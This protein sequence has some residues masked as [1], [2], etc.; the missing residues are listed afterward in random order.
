MHQFNPAIS[1]V[2]VFSMLLIIATHYLTWKNINSYQ[3]ATIGVSCFLFISGYLYGQKKITNSFD[4]L[5]RR[6]FRVLVPFWILSSLLSI[7][8]IIKGEYFFAFCQ[9]IETTLNMQGI[10]SILRLPFE[11]GHFHL[12]GL[13]HCCFLTVIMLCYLAVLMLKR[14]QLEKIVLRS[15]AVTFLG[16]VVLHAVLSFINVAIGCFVIFFIGYFYRLLSDTD[17]L[18]IK[19]ITGMTAVMVVAVILRLVLKK[20]IDGEGIYD[21]F[22][23]SLSSNV[24]AIWCFVVIRWL[25]ESKP[26]FAKVAGHSWWKK[27]DL[28]TYP[29]FLTHYMFLKEPF[30][31]T[32]LHSLNLFTEFALFV[33]L[34]LMC[35]IILNYIVKML[36]FAMNMDK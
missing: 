28:I 13:A 14:F 11:F 35:A 17:K 19:K 29:L 7:Y 2:R 6:I 22:V 10:H 4:W 27:V 33:V 32:K 26:I 21:L 31:L 3:I 18:S 5:K 12:S 8:L 1:L 25:C 30:N 9:L 16:I 15:P 36:S 23:A 34:S 24:C 20:M